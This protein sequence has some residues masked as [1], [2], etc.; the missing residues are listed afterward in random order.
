MSHSG[1]YA[2]IGTIRIRKNLY[3]DEDLETVDMPHFGQHLGSVVTF[4]VID[5]RNA[6][7]W[8]IKSYSSDTVLGYQISIE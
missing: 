3:F 2:A 1:S 5:E 8:L 7:Y 6:Q 4:Y